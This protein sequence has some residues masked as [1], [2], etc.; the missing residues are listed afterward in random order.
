MT[1]VLAYAIPLLL[2]VALAIGQYE[3]NKATQEA[4]T[5]QDDWQRNG[6]LPLDREQNARLDKIEAHLGIQGDSNETR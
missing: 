1:K 6:E 5:W 4:L 3:Q 2:W